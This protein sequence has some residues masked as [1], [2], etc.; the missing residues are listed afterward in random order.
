MTT[1]SARMG[2]T[3]LEPVGSDESTVLFEEEG[4]VV[5]QIASEDEKAAAYRLRH[6]IFCGELKWVLQ[7]T[8]GMEHDEYDDNAIFFGVFDGQ[9]RLVSFLR[10]ILPNRQFMMEKAFLSLVDPSH[11]IRKEADTAEISRLCVAPEVRNSRTGGNFG[12]HKISLLLCKAV[13]QW[14]KL[15]N[16]RFLYAVTELKVYRLYCLTGFLYRTIGTPV[17]MPDGVTAVAVM[18]DWDEF[19]LVNAAKRPE[20]LAWFR[21]S[22]VSSLPVRSQQH[23]PCSTHSVF[24]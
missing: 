13:Y 18:L 22:R 14:C 16:V 7:S 5:K 8:N 10:L 12:V 3:D 23:G 21:K 11:R 24:A 4:F 6:S 20:F 17:K 2:Y 19:E 9:Q 1:Q 15:N